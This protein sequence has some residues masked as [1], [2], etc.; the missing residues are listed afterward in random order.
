M[1]LQQPMQGRGSWPVIKLPDAYRAKAHHSHV[2]SRQG[3]FYDCS[4]CNVHTHPPYSLAIHIPQ[5]QQKWKEVEATK[6]KP[7][8][9]ALPK[10]PEE[11]QQPLPTNA[12]DIDAFNARMFDFWNKAVLVPCQGCGRTF[13]YNMENS[14]FASHF[15]HDSCATHTLPLITLLATPIYLPITVGGN[16]TQLVASCW[17]L[18]NRLVYCTRPE[19]LEHHAKV[20]KA[21]GGAASGA[22]NDMYQVRY[23]WTGTAVAHTTATI[24]WPQ[25]RLLLL[26]HVRCCHVAL[27]C[28]VLCF[29]C[30]LTA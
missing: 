19:A 9:R 10:I 6:P 17:L 30:C 26:W 8:R 5:C 4:N 18:V 27:Q 24:Q 23:R 11:L 14:T 7:Q 1:P 12:A 20:C 13:R 29:L 25:A 2:A 15:H 21:G 16:A 28:T 22:G 3:S